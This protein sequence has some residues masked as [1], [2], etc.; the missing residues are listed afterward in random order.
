MRQILKILI[1]IALIC[2]LAAGGSVFAAPTEQPGDSADRVDITTLYPSGFISTFTSKSFTDDFGNTYKSGIRFGVNWNSM[3]VYYEVA[4][5]SRLTAKVTVKANDRE[6]AGAGSKLIFYSG[7]FRWGGKREVI[8]ET[9]ELSSITQ[10]LD[11]TVDLTGVDILEIECHFGYEWTEVGLADAYLE[12]SS[13]AAVT[14]PISTPTPRPSDPNQITVTLDGVVIEF[15]Q[16][17]I[18]ENGRTLVP[19]RKIFEAMGATVEWDGETHTATGRKGDIVIVMRIGNNIITKNG[20]QITLDVPPKAVNGRTLVPVRAVAEGFNCAVEWDGDAQKVVISTGA[21]KIN[22]GV[23]ETWTKGYDWRRNSVFSRTS[24]GYFTI[25]NGDY[26]AAWYELK[27]AV[28]KNAAYRLS[29][30][31]KLE[32]FSQGNENPGGASV[33]V[34][35]DEYNA[36]YVTSNTW[37]KSVI[38]FNSE[39]R[40]EVTLRLKMGN[41]SATVKG[42]AYFG[43]IV[44]EK[45]KETTEDNHWN[46]LTLIY[47]N[48]SAP[49]YKRSFSDKEIKEFTDAM[50]NLPYAFE[51]LSA[52]RMVV[53]KIDTV[54]IDEPIKTVS[55]ANGSLAP[56]TDIDIDKYLDGKDYSQ[57]IVI[58]PLSGAGTESWQ[59]LG[60]TAYKNIWYIA[61]RGSSYQ[62][63]QF[64][65]AGKTYDGKVCVFV[66]EILHCVD[67]NARQRGF[68]GFL[69]LHDTTIGGFYDDHV[70]WLDWYA[71]KMQNVGL[72]GKG[73]PEEAF[74]V[75]HTDFSDSTVIDLGR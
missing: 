20:Q 14:P 25:E 19:V 22:T 8:Y 9:E 47:K 70:G 74:L 32:N 16:P 21:G 58:A 62:N 61:V 50:D 67:T 45:A 34:D 10:P 35:V 29:A 5:Y 69:D 27:I 36:D 38:Q 13:A 66:H 28:E 23:K 56:G 41:H 54:I 44:L 12:K 57:I 30:D 73:L 2:A 11:I 51:N 55:N 68:S 4:E 18:A 64:A 65:V 72:D 59:G 48:V 43:N 31:I 33:G 63:K 17:P 42:K 26:N 46:I 71:A 49:A 37:G 15:D 75:T 3:D 53:D 6:K 7:T 39:N 52:G 40:T 60:G 1:S 24:D